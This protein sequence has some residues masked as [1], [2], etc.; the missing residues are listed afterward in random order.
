MQELSICNLFKHCE[1]MIKETYF[2]LGLRGGDMSCLGHV[3]PLMLRRVLTLLLLLILNSIS[4]SHS[5]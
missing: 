1:V 4:V 5:N 3:V 2:N